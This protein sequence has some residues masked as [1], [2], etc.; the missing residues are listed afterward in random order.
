MTA[1]T[2]YRRRGPANPELS[3]AV[4]EAW[5]KGMS[6]SAVGDLVGLNKNQVIG[7]VN[8]ARKR[9]EFVA[10]K[11]EAQVA[12]AE[13][14]RKRKLEMQ[15]RPVEVRPVSLAKPDVAY[16]PALSL[17]IVVA[18]PLTAETNVTIMD[19]DMTTC[20]Y[21]TTPDIS[22]DA[23]YCGGPIERGAYCTHHAALCYEEPR[24]RHR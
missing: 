22:I 13:T 10:V 12:A 6:S 7:L 24:K 3:A 16:A 5:N 19:L 14:R 11:S 4:I 9:G 1:N 23:P 21:L 8:R 17:P 20:R 2:P 18:H 15:G